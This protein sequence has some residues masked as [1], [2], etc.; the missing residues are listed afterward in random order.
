MTTEGAALPP[1]NAVISSQA[2]NN[3]DPLVLS[4]VSD[5]GWLRPASR[6]HASPAM[7]R[8]PATWLGP[9]C[10]SSQL[11]RDAGCRQCAE[12][13]GALPPVIE[14]GAVGTGGEEVAQRADDGEAG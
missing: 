2:L 11:V 6:L 5:S 12:R 14:E 4:T 1:T 3:A 8:A 9:P 10:R 13:A 7:K